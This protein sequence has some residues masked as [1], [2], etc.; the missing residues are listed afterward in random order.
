MPTRPRASHPKWCEAPDDTVEPGILPPR[1]PGRGPR[2][3]EM[4][5]TVS[6]SLR[7][8]AVAAP[9]HVSPSRRS[10]RRLRASPEPTSQRQTSAPACRPLPAPQGDPSPIGHEQR[11]AVGHA[12]AAVRAFSCRSALNGD[13]TGAVAWL[14]TPRHAKAPTSTPARARLSALADSVRRQPRVPRGAARG[15]P[16]TDSRGQSLLN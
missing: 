9:L 15:R 2:V 12:P 14:T 10:G 16:R 13:T 3:R 7:P 6:R 11:T 5:L 4:T 1:I 8:T